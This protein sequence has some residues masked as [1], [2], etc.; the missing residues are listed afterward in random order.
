MKTNLP[1]KLNSPQLVSTSGS[2]FSDDETLSPPSSPGHEF[3]KNENS[4]E[5]SGALNQNTLSN[6]KGNKRKRI[7]PSSTTSK[8]S[9]KKKKNAKGAS[10]LLS[11]ATCAILGCIAIMNPTTIKQSTLSIYETKDNAPKVGPS[12]GVPSFSG[13]GKV[14]FASHHH[15]ISRRL[16]SVPTVDIATQ[17]IFAGNADSDIDCTACNED[18]MD[19][20]ISPLEMYPARWEVDHNS[21]FSSPWTA[22]TSYQLLDLALPYSDITNKKSSLVPLSSSSELLT[23]LPKK[24]EDDTPSSNTTNTRKLRGSKALDDDLSYADKK[25]TNEIISPISLSSQSSDGMSDFSS[26]GD[27]LDVGSSF[28]FCPDAHASLSPGLIHLLD[29]KNNLH[30]IS[31]EAKIKKTVNHIKKGGKGVPFASKRMSNISNSNAN[32]KIVQNMDNEF[33]SSTRSKILIENS[34]ADLNPLDDGT[35]KAL[36]PSQQTKYQN[37]FSIL[38]QDERY[39]NSLYDKSNPYMTF[40]VPASILPLEDLDTFEDL[41]ISSERPQWVELGCQIRSARL[42]TGVDFVGN[43]NMD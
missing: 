3:S 39:M 17:E 2:E 37:S 34:K 21:P 42:V 1:S 35:D 28:A 19:W 11:V 38:E 20:V 13:T 23:S 25:N 12:V 15:D 24:E 33:M 32:S 4:I 16:M 22:E 40:L 6:M 18:K 29:F 7:S 10:F 26:D 5:S 36:V 27:V 14:D 41:D 30:D 43:M 8:L 9:T 31:K